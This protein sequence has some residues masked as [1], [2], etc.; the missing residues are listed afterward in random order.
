MKILN[1]SALFM[2]LLSGQ[3]FAQRSAGLTHQPDTSFSNY[4]AYKNALKKYPDITI[5]KD[6][7]PSSVTAVKD[8]TYRTTGGRE[9][10]IDAFYPK[11]QR[12][13]GT[14]FKQYPA[15]L[16][17]YGGGWRSGNRQQHTALAE[18]L[19]AK[20]Y[21]CFT[22][23]YTLSTEALYPAAVYDLKAAI[24]WIRTN[25][26]TYR[27]SSQRLAVLGFSAG[28][29]LASLLSTTGDLPLFDEAGSDSKKST[30]VQA[31]I[32]ID[33]TLSFVHPESGEGDDSKKPSAATLW[34]GYS[35]KEN[36]ELWKQA[37][38]LTYAGAQTPPTLFIN[39]SIDRM[40]AGRNDFTSILNQYHIYNEVYTFPDS[41]HA[42]CL[43]EPWFTPT[44]NYIVSFLDKVFKK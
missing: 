12:I 8:I 30:K 10:K 31:L 14:K 29:Q 37:S 43:F 5:A 7:L 9:L 27:V 2:V 33:G 23:D 42:F 20:G 18:Q 40:H 19:A 16:I 6:S 26:S 4:S 41:P 35:K 17:I 38:P 34:F 32:D 1:L 28:G 39:S 15:V 36:P 13:H 24:R 3:V 11:Y 25:A 22:V 21:A 44:V